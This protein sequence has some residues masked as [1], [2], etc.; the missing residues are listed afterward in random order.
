MKKVLITGA[1]GFLGQ[2]LFVYL[3]KRNY[4]VIAT[5]RGPCKLV[6]KDTAVYEEAELTDRHEVIAMLN[7]HQP[8]VIV[9][10]AAMS[11]P[12]ECN[13]DKGKCLQVNVAATKYLLEASNAFF[14]YISTDFIFGEN[15]PH[16]EHQQPDPLNFYGE[17]KL[18]AE[19]VV[20]DSGKAYAIVRP[21]FIYGKVFE[22]SRDTFLHWVKKNL[23]QG[24]KIKVVS[25]Q[26]RTPTYVDD[27]CAGIDAIITRQATGAFHLA[28][29][30]I[31][32]P[33][34]M[35]VTTANVLGLD[36]SLIENV[37]SET[38]PEP[39]RRAKRSG[40][41]I[42]KAIAQLDYVP[43]SFDEGVRLSFNQ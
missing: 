7:K 42:Q 15:G 17:S 31:L 14:I 4:E 24:N 28:G 25:D 29:K 26:Q 38:F 16:D 40:L 39:V 23:E 11:K 22:G 18:L 12:D 36:T 33:Y 43:V 34:Q 27:I 6:S 21:V 2:H 30:D 19:K 13:N 10:T 37:T 3:S 41:I 1:N 8:D 20:K 32:S 35:A 5:G 9:H